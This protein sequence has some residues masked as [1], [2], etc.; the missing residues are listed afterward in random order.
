[1]RKQERNYAF[2]DMQ[3]LHLGIQELGWKLDYKKFRI[4]L[5]EKYSV[6]VAFGFIG[7][8]AENQKLYTNLAEAGYQLVF[9]TVTLDSAGA[10]KG[11]V[12]ADLVLHALVTAA[13]YDRAVIVSGDGD[14]YSLVAHLYAQDSLE[15][16][17]SP[18]RATSSRLLRSAAH[19]RIHFLETT[20]KRLEYKRKAP[21]RDETRGSA[22]P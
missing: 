2:I 20:R 21:P 5:K 3:N 17:L 12:D 16:V 13:A 8:V 18:N 10:T 7:Y 6:Q 15:A 9:K 14:F 19:E 4:Y 1:M 11:N 22:L